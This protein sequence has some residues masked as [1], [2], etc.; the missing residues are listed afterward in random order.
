MAIRAFL[1]IPRSTL[2]LTLTG[3]V[4]VAL[5]LMVAIVTGVARLDRV[6]ASSYAAAIRISEVGQHGRAVVDHLLSME[7][8]LGQY[9][10]FR[11]ERFYDT[12]KSRRSAMRR[13]VSAL[14][15]LE[16]GDEFQGRLSAFSS[17]E[18]QIHANAATADISVVR[19]LWEDLSAQARAID[20][21]G[22]A[23]AEA[24]VD[25]AAA[26]ARDAQRLLLT[27]TAGVLPV[28]MLLAALF[29]ALITRPIRQVD[30]AIR[31]LAA[32]S[33][34]EPVEIQGP[35]DL[36]QVGECL[37]ALRRKVITLEREKFGFL[38]R[39]SHE[40]KT[41]L[42]SIRQ[43]AELLADRAGTTEAEALEIGEMLKD[44]SL[45]LQRLIEDL[46]EFGKTQR[47]AQVPTLASPINVLHILR[48]ILAAHALT[49]RTRRIRLETEL[50]DAMV[51]GDAM[52]LQTIINNLIANA[53]KYTPAGGSLRVSL[54]SYNDDREVAIDV[55]DSGPGIPLEDRARV[56]EPFFQGMPAPGSHVKGTG[57]GLAIAR[58]Y[59][60]AHHGVI[61][62]IDSDAGAHFRVRLP[63]APA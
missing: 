62:I 17:L 2:G 53:V 11:E 61:E 14:A 18:E 43:G 6:A 42:T 59:V 8:S 26:G 10:V 12:Y 4:L 46:L 40:L 27:A 25:A 9:R 5:P 63:K 21:V 34:G 23:L 7:R 32:D 47:L 31:R 52:Q 37:D 56:F 45:E 39:I 16:L 30:E 29:A 49:L 20:E 28:S 33:F 24:E 50:G 51:L 36:E 44:S 22:R 1:P 58:E 15:S 3:F 41:P 60:E 48:R 55:H 54:G 35:R 19:P 38:R 57:L 13:S